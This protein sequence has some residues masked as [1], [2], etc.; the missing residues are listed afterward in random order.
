MKQDEKIMKRELFVDREGKTRFAR[1]AILYSGSTLLAELAGRVGFDTV[2]ID[3]EHCSTTFREAESLCLAVNAGGAVPTIRISEHQR[4][5]ILRALEVGAG[6]VV[7]PMVNTEEQARKMVEW[8][9]FPPLGQRG[10]NNRSRGVEFGLESC[11]IAFS[12]ANDRTYLFAQIETRQGVDNIE[13]ICSVEGL[14]GIFIGPGDLSAALG[15]MGEF[16]NPQLIKTSIECIR[17]A[18]RMGKHAGILVRPGK[19]LD[20]A[21]QAGCDLAFFAGDVMDLSRIWPEVLQDV[22]AKEKRL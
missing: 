11:S 10:F 7:V 5:Y 19:L 2:W 3:M 8:G 18:R 21:I 15:G 6:I 4:T 16:D 9:K 20:A 22:R 12:K 17:I 14:G 1:G 13:D